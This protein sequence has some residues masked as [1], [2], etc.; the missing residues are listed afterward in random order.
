M[1][2][3]LSIPHGPD[4]LRSPDR[5]LAGKFAVVTGGS[6]D[7]GRG[8]VEALASEG[9][10]VIF[11]YNNKTKRAYDVI[12]SVEGA[13]GTAFAIPGDTSTSEGRGAFFATA[14]MISRGKL[15]FL[16]LSASGQTEALNQDSSGDFLDKFLPQMD[17]GGT[18]VQLQS[19]PS[20]A[21]EQLK[22]SHSL[23]EYDNVAINKNKN[24]RL[25][26]KRIPEMQKRGIRFM[27]VC[28]P[29]VSDTN[30]VRF[31]NSR[32]ATAEAQHNDVT[33]RLGLPR[34]VTSR[35]VG[36]RVVQ[37][38][39]N[40][41]IESGHIEFFNV[42]KDALTPL[43]SVYGTSAIYVNTLTEVEDTD[44][45]LSSVDHIGHAIISREQATRPSEPEMIDGIRLST[46]PRGL[47]RVT[48][49]H[50]RGYFSK[51]SELPLI[52]PGHKQIRAAIDTIAAI[53]RRQGRD[54]IIKLQEFEGATFSK[55]VPADGKTVLEINPVLRPD[56]AYDVDILDAITGERISSILGLKVRPAT[57]ADN[58]SL[59]EDQIIEGAA[60]A[61]GILQADG[62]EMKMPLLTRI[63]RTQ[64]VAEG[65]KGGE[66]I[67][68]HTSS[69]KDEKRGVQG[70]VAIYSEGRIIGTID[71]I[72]AVLVS[73]NLASRLL[74]HNS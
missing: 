34:S 36:N 14:S 4:A 72:E 56:G 10:T 18:V 33:D 15:D 68:Y 12:K 21:M 49:E 11:S 41:D 46:P 70:S 17:E 31:A 69:K 58:D 47:L 65:I 28:P 62:S 5:P 50:A 51:E 6:R 45:P 23:G 9:V 37:L 61:V 7:V 59:F 40:P 60:Q 48:Q 44:N 22:G 43:E 35:Q 64:F 39:R 74:T 67:S 66:G 2:A 73:K 8:I 16:I 53:E 63:G 38:L 25:M 71:K 24:L 55:I 13:G 3:E 20:H 27:V 54:G 1:P 32:D 29:I 19:V 26:R 52:L 57:E 42:A 30:N